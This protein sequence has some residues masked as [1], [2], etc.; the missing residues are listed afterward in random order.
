MA[1]STT[2]L[3]NNFLSL[4]NEIIELILHDN[5]LECRDITSIS[6][7]CMRLRTLCQ[8][9]ELWR[10][11]LQ[12]RWPNL[13]KR[14]SRTKSHDWL[15]EYKICHVTPKKVAAMVD[16]LSPAYYQV[17]EVSKEGFSEFV[18]LLEEN[19]AGPIIL[20]TLLDIVNSEKDKHK[21]LTRKFYATKVIRH[22]TLKHLT[23]KW[24]EHIQLPV[25]HQSLE[26]GAVMLAQWCQPSL[27]ITENEIS[28]QLDVIAAK[29]ITQCPPVIAEKI[30]NGRT[31]E[32]TPPQ[33]RT[34]LENVNQVLYYDIGFHGNSEDYYNEKNS[35]INQVLNLK[36][37]IP[38]TLS[39]VY[40][41]VAK[42]LGIEL[43]PV[44]F[45]SHFLIKWKEHP[46]GTPENQYTYIDA[47]EKG[48]FLTQ[49][50]LSTRIGLPE[51]MANLAELCRSVP[52]VMVY[53]RMTRNLIIIGR[54]QGFGQGQLLGLRNAMELYLVIS[55]DDAEVL[56]LQARV[57][58]HLNVD[59]TDV[60]DN[61]QRTESFDNRQAL[62]AHLLEE[63][64][65][66]MLNYESER[67]K[68]R[69]VKQRSDNPNVAFAVGMVMRHRRYN[70]MC[71]IYGWDSKCQASQEWIYQMGVNH[72]P[73]KDKQPFYNVLVD[74]GSN[75]YAAQENLEIPDS[76]PEI[77]HPE[78]GKY[79]HEFSG[80]HYIPNNEKLSEYPGDMEIVHKLLNSGGEKETDM[81]ALSS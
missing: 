76:V 17:D 62:V 18:V 25:D 34:V 16:Q 48:R 66:Q 23:T 19:E 49:V 64:R 3:E 58:L 5:D 4:P 10:R 50:E 20:D 75:R 73:K 45:P 57:N 33:Q 30:N 79:F 56:M 13:L 14:Y 38:I 41:S 6:S 69:K 24:K 47:Y 72:L 77:A 65:R 21:N 28:D 52:P 61:L 40:I 7:T 78:V 71:A 80:N 32:L 22:I 54:Q 81:D 51:E 74:D 31:C 15:K 27:S 12:L 9:N 46:M 55:P 67:K 68:K 44:N 59:L 63:A 8:S 1:A 60:I 29:V 11:Q 2:D 35:Y 36:S 70:Y 26:T 43:H 39:I 53:Q 42:R 37:G